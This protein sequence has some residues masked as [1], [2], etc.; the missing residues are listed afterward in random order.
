[1]KS[2]NWESPSEDLQN[3]ISDYIIKSGF[4][5]ELQVRDLL[6]KVSAKLLDSGMSYIEHHTTY[7]D[8][9]EGV[10]REIDLT[11]F[12]GSLNKIEP[13]LMY[14]YFFECKS[15]EKYSWVFFT[16]PSQEH[17]F[18]YLFTANMANL[19]IIPDLSGNH[20]R[21]LGSPIFYEHTKKF[22][23]SHMSFPDGSDMIRSAI[24][25]AIKPCFVD[26]Q[27]YLDDL[28]KDEFEFVECAVLYFPVVVYSGYMF[29]YLH[30]PETGVDTLAPIN[31]VTVIF[32]HS[33]NKKTLKFLVDVVRFDHLNTYLTQ[34]IDDIRKIN[35]Y[36]EKNKPKK[37]KVAI[38]KTI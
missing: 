32:E 27:N 29:E 20:E 4:P 19:E 13:Y 35:D 15:S 25:Q 30:D 1:M 36:V 9:E 31:H 22:A 6:I 7:I 33:F 17:Q 24:I 26:S 10:L 23:Y 38:R 21:A 2:N 5:L 11:W 18:P 8:P 16:E 34:Q 12:I 3:K 37:K 14:N 28:L